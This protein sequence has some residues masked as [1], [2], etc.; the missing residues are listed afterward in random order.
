MT[1]W[2]MNRSFSGP[3]AQA[4]GYYNSYNGSRAG[5]ATW[6]NPQNGNKGFAA[7]AANPAT[8]NWAYLMGQLDQASQ[9]ATLKGQTSNGSSL[10]IMRSPE[11]SHFY[12]NGNN[13]NI[14]MNNGE[15]TITTPNKTINIFNNSVDSPAQ[16][17]SSSSSNS[18]AFAFAGPKRSVAFASA[19]SNNSRAVAF[20]FAG[21]NGSAAFARSSGNA[22]SASAAA[23]S[24]SSGSSASAS[25]TASSSCPPQPQ[26]V[27][28]PQPQPVPPPQPQPVPPPQPQPVPPPQPQPVPPPQPQPVPPPQPQPVPPPEKKEVPP[29]PVAA[30]ETASMIGDPH[31]TGG[32]GGTFDVHGVPGESYNVLSDQGLQMNATMD[33]YKD[34]GNIVTETAI[35]VEGENGYESLVYNSDGTATYNDVPLENGQ[36]ID[37]ADGGSATLDGYKLTVITAEGYQIEQ[38]AL[39]WD[40]Y[41]YIN[42]TITTPE[43]GVAADGVVPDGILGSTFD[44]DSDQT[45]SVKD[46]NGNEYL[47]EGDTVTPLDHHKVE[48]V[49]DTSKAA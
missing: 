34:Q 35:N 8:G 44:E 2:V 15:G 37:L 32:D 43:E 29:S 30:N 41:D 21:P 17:Q 12:F 16:T 9:T 11:N 42:T 25:A 6:N 45:S 36:T 10:D 4:Q 47:V 14:N 38:E 3:N 39:T 33:N 40:G 46:Q 22:S 20:A 19:S 13:V 48:D 5:L 26:P 23:A 31:C 27:P 18:K 28:P 24:S 1:Q 49:S 7:G